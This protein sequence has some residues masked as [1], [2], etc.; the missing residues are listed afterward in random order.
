MPNGIVNVVSNSAVIVNA[1]D[2]VVVDSHATPAS[3]RALVEDIRT[4]TPKPMRYVINT[5]DASTGWSAEV[6]VLLHPATYGD[7]ILIRL[8]ADDSRLRQA[9]QEELTRRTAGLVQPDCA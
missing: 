4:I 5:D 3:A 8:A 6:R 2:V 1:D 7:P 9:P